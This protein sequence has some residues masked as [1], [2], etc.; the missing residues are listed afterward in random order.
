MFHSFKCLS[1]T[2]LFAVDRPKIFKSMQ[3]NRESKY[4]DNDKIKLCPVNFSASIMHK[5]GAYKQTK[6]VL[7]TANNN[8]IQRER[9]S[10]SFQVR[11]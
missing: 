6:P 11:T 5:I 1:T 3:I 7:A 2:G 4:Q 8:E 9:P 10:V